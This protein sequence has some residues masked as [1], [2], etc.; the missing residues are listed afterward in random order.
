MKTQ[1]TINRNQFYAYCK[2][3]YAH[4]RF[5]IEGVCIDTNLQKIRIIY[6]TSNGKITIAITNSAYI[7]TIYGEGVVYFTSEDGDY[8]AWCHVD[9]TPENDNEEYLAEIEKL[10][11]KLPE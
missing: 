5:Y 6:N 4:E 9:F 2:V 7:K 10:G 3:Q 8:I 11:Y 1:I